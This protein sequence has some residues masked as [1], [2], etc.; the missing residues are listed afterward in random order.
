[1]TKNP[2]KRENF[3]T[4]LEIPEI[5]SNE[6]LSAFLKREIELL[7]KRKTSAKPRKNAANAPIKETIL[8]FLAT[9]PRFAVNEI[10]LGLD[11]EYSCQK[12][13]ALLNQL[14]KEGTVERVV[15]KNKSFYSVI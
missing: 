7:D 13:T 2:T 15:E 3:A 4:L 14:C 6:Q 10:V 1:M 12:I 5:A 11:K 8:N 9:G